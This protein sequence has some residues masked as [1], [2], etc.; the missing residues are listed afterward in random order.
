MHIVFLPIV[1]IRL[2]VYVYVCV[3]YSNCYMLNMFSMGLTIIT[4]S[5]PTARRLVLSPSSFQ[6]I[7][8]V[9]LKIAYSLYIQHSFGMCFMHIDII[10]LLEIGIRR[11]FP[12]SRNCVG[13]CC[14]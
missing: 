14:V 11:V 10:R 12:R 4:T 13:L 3:L 5:T 6:A 1:F 7:H 8:K 9:L 2:W